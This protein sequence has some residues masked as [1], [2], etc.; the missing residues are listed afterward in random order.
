[1]SDVEKEPY[2]FNPGLEAEELEDWLSQQVRYL[3]HFNKLKKERAALSA[4][5]S[6]IDSALDYYAT[7][8]MSGRLS[9]PWE[10]SPLLKAHQK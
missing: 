4:Q 3:S 2:F 9:F 5:L 8:V 7:E 10:P 1:M 6:E